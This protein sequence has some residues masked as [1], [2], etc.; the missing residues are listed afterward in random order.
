MPHLLASHNGMRRCVECARRRLVHQ[1]A[2]AE[3]ASERPCRPS[4]L[5]F[6]ALQQPHHIGCRSRGEVR[7]LL[8]ESI[9]NYLKVLMATLAIHAANSQTAHEIASYRRRRQYFARLK[10]KCKL[11]VHPSWRV[12]TRF[13]C[14]KVIAPSRSQLLV[15]RVY[16]LRPQCFAC[17]IQTYSP[18]RRC[19]EQDWHIAC[20]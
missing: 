8:I 16:P 3:V 5:F 20:S 14:K 13:L 19:G 9:A 12:H 10:L 17:L 2:F 15:A 6:V 18:P 7:S 1:T 11:L 4:T